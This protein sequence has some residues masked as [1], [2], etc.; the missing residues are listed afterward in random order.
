[1]PIINVTPLDYTFS[2]RNDQLSQSIL[3]AFSRAISSQEVTYVDDGFYTIPGTAASYGPEKS[4]PQDPNVQHIAGQLGFQSRQFGT[5]EPHATIYI[6]KKVFSTLRDNFDVKFLGND[7]KLFLRATKQLF[8][9]KANEVAAYERLTK[10]K[11]FLDEGVVLKQDASWMMSQLESGLLSG[12]MK[13]ADA[14][15]KKAEEFFGETGKGGSAA[16]KL[17]KKADK[18]KSDSEKVRA[19]T[20]IREANIEDEESTY[21]RWTIGP[22]ERDVNGIGLG[23][24]V[25]ELT[26]FTNFSTN[27]SLDM[28]SLGSCSLSIE[29][30]YHILFIKVEDIDKAIVQ[31][32]PDLGQPR[33]SKTLF[34]DAQKLEQEF[35]QQF[36]T[37]VTI[38]FNVN[39]G[40]VSEPEW[41]KYSVTNSR[42][43]EAKAKTLKSLIVS[44][45]SN[46]KTYTQNF[47]ELNKTTNY[48]RNK[49]LKFYN[50]KAIVQPMDSIHIFINGN[51]TL[52]SY[53]ENSIT[54]ASLEVDISRV[55]EDKRVVLGEGTKEEGKR[56][57]INKYFAM[58]RPDTFYGAQTFAGVVD[59]VT[60]NYNASAGK[61][62]LSIKAS[63]N[64]KWLK[65]SR[66][67]KSPALVQQHGM[68][69]DPLTPFLIIPDEDGMI[70]NKLELLPENKNLMQQWLLSIKGGIDDGRVVTEK[71]FIGLNNN[72]FEKDFVSI[73]HLPGFK[74]RWK[75]G[76]FSASQDFSIKSPG[77]AFNT[78]EDMQKLYGIT[79]TTTPFDNLDAANLIS[80]LVTGFP[81]SFEKF[82]RNSLNAGTLNI[83]SAFNGGEGFFDTLFDAIKQQNKTLGNF[84][85]YTL[86]GATRSDAI[87]N[88]KIAQDAVRFSSRRRRIKLEVARKED[89]IAEL[90]R[91]IEAA[92]DSGGQRGNISN[93]RVDALVKTVEKDISVLREKI[94]ELEDQE[95]EELS[96]AEASAPE[97]S[98]CEFKTKG[99][100]SI[101]G[102][103]TFEEDAKKML[104]HFIYKRK[105]DIK[106]NRD[107]NLFIVS[108]E[109]E[110]NQDIQAFVLNLKKQSP[111]L[112]ENVSAYTYPLEICVQAAKSLDFEFFADANGHIHF[113]PPQYNKTPLCIL[114]QMFSLGKTERKTYP[115]F[116]ENL[117]TNRLK[118]AEKQ[119]TETDLLMEYKIAIMLGDVQEAQRIVANSDFPRE[120]KPDEKIIKK[121]ID[122]LTKGRAANL[123]TALLENEIEELQNQSKMLNNFLENVEVQGLYAGLDDEIDVLSKLLK[124]G[125]IEEDASINPLNFHLIEFDNINEIGYASG[126]RFIIN[127]DAIINYNF[128]EGDEGIITRV[129]VLGIQEMTGT[130]FGTLAISQDLWAGAVD[131]DLW[132]Q[133]GYRYADS[134]K[135][136]FNDA[137]SQC[138]PYAAFLLNRQKR[139]IIKGSITLVG[140]EYYQLGDVVYVTDR[141]LLYY[142]T[143]VSHAFDYNS[144]SFTTTLQLRYGHVPG[145]Y[146]PTPLDIIGRTVIGGNRKQFNFVRENTIADR[147]ERTLAGINFSNESVLSDSKNFNSLRNSY[148]IARNYIS[149]ENEVTLILRCFYAED[150]E[151]GNKVTS[152]RN[153]ETIKGWFRTPI[154][155]T[156]EVLVTA[157]E[158]AIDI[159]RVET[160]IVKLLTPAD[161]PEDE[162]EKVLSP[163]EE[164]FD[165]INSGVGPSSIVE[166]LLSFETQKFRERK[167]Q[168]Y[169]NQP[170]IVSEQPINAEVESSSPYEP[171]YSHTAGN[172]PEA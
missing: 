113:R 23:S 155:K 122:E 168:D 17:R 167:N 110:K 148:T 166:I 7:E 116:L 100:F 144:G 34:D 118:M 16:S 132:Q 158:C 74:Y 114:R 129:D 160:Q 109:Y 44:Y 66:I 134:Q 70:S 141:E 21:T 26:S 95:K 143:G 126:R 131:F 120:V 22:T 57:P 156:G 102:G 145:D 13:E 41:D 56:F 64:L 77:V 127:D 171:S 104:E 112:Y 98:T 138:R 53:T 117:F 137:E 108:D 37:P 33:L 19:E 92:S 90:R 163:T 60:D 105:S 10:I 15:A 80:L 52:Q 78:R 51:T 150:E 88:N 55:K 62:T 9:N 6:K 115:P 142:V 84:V 106:F 103:S 61:Y 161:L 89:K 153:V 36:G 65:V 169:S 85:P 99:S 2:N 18:L 97:N 157:N 82:L 69:E 83:D 25:I 29:D 133:Y 48:I 11:R 71:S 38:N 135:P 125:K 5:Q 1:M 42:A 123:K 91:R 149:K 39:T 165:L 101:I 67:N 28:G 43:A 45:V 96:S 68:L 159:N 130:S 121:Y 147:N 79:L 154:D 31:T 8:F 162:D 76:M 50:G 4:R 24:G 54:G 111:E 32:R 170:E 107:V 59:S 81:Y 146:I 20:K 40:D 30:P 164:T 152:T 93:P 128:T 75:E 73:K 172:E 12:Q 124:G 49:M 14:A 94:K 151:G 58:R 35:L 119:K 47:V 46:A 136:F 140:N 27:L 3:E 86:I 87:S 72:D 63:N 139:D